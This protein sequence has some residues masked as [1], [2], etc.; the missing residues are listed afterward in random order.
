[1]RVIVW[2]DALSIMRKFN[3]V[4]RVESF[5]NVLHTNWRRFNEANW[6]IFPKLLNSIGPKLRVAKFYRR[7]VNVRL[8]W[9]SKQLTSS[10]EFSIG[11]SLMEG[12]ASSKDGRKWA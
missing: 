3:H 10:V 5:N 8:C 11:P 4:H 7:E 12:S 6:T 9:Y 2:S 1:M